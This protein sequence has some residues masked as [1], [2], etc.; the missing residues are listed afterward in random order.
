MLSRFRTALIALLAAL[1]LLGALPAFAQ[2]FT[3]ADQQA[4]AQYTLSTSFLTRC[5]AI[6]HDVQK[7]NVSVGDAMVGEG[8]L[9]QMAARLDAMPDMHAIL[10]AHKMAAREYLI[11][12][13]VLVRAIMGARMLDDPEQAGDF[14]PDTTLLGNITF[15]RVHRDEIETMMKPPADAPG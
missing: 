8:G 11:G 4:L 1:A 12:S 15:Y 13:V 3:D 10:T 7:Q 6:V 9:D 5:A 14:D 2:A